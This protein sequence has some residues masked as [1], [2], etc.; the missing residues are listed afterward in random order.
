MIYAYDLNNYTLYND[1]LTMSCFADSYSQLQ[2]FNQQ[3]GQQGLYKNQIGAIGSALAHFS[4]KDEPALIAM[5]TGTGKTAVMVILSYL[6]KANKVLVVTPSQLVREQIA[7]YFRLPKILIDKG[8]IPSSVSLP[9]VY[10]LTTII[11]KAEDWREILDKYDVIVGIPGTLSQIPDLDVTIGKNAF[12]TVF[13]DEA[14]HSRAKSWSFILS[15]FSD[16]RQVLLTATPFRRDK[17][18]IKARLIY[19][20]PLKQ[21]YEDKLFSKINF[22]PVKTQ[23]F[24]TE[25]DKNIA[26]AKKAAEVYLKRKHPDHKIIIRTDR[27]KEAKDLLDIYSEHT[28]L[29]LEVIH[30][31]LNQRTIKQK[32]KQLTTGKINGIICVDMMGE[33]YDFPALKIAAIHIPHK[34]LAITLQFVGRISRTNIAEGDIATVIAGEYEFKIESHQLYKQDTK[35]WS[36]ILPD[37]HS[38]KI[39]KTEDEQDFFDSFEDITEP[40]SLTQLEIDEPLVLDDDDLKPFFH[41]KLYT[42]TPGVTPDLLSETSDDNCPV[43][44]HAQIDFSGTDALKNPVIRH[45]HVSNSYEVAVYVVSE[46]KKPDWYIGSNALRD[47]QNELFVIYFDK[48]NS[49]LFI[50][51]SIK[52]NELY[53]H[54]AIQY[55]SNGAVHEMI[56]LPWLKRA[57]AGWHNPKMYNIGM[58]SRK[59]KGNSETYKQLL[60][61]VAQKGVL[62]TD[63]YSYT[64]GHSFGGAYDAILRRD[65]LL[66][67]STGSKIWSLEENKI[68][69]IVE[70]C[71]RIARKVGDPEMD[72][73][74]SPLSEL[75]CGRVIDRLPDEDIFF[76]DW[77]ASQYH[78]VTKIVFLDQDNEAVET[79]LL[80]SCSIHVLSKDAN[81]ITLVVCKGEAESKI[82]YRIKPKVSFLYAED[83]SCKIA[84]RIGDSYGNTTNFLAILD[85]CPINVFYEDMSKL[86]G[87]V[88]FKFNADNIKSISPEQLIS[89]TW[90]ITVNIHKEYYSETDI[91]NNTARNDQRASIHDYIIELANKEYDAVFYD[92]GSLEIADVIGFKNDKIQFYHCKKQNG[93]VPNCNIDDIYE[94]C[95]QALKSVHWANRKL[96]VKQLYDRA[97]QNDN[98]RKVKKGT[99]P[100]IKDI[101]DSFDNPIIPVE[102]TIVQPGLKTQNL[103]KGQ[104]DALERIKLLLSGA[105][106]FLKEVSSCNLSVMCS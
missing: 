21:A 9:K 6:L 33:G 36:I 86:I 62:P 34:S 26:I 73:L 101:L 74:D 42:I 22:V 7:N 92:H 2:I 68:K 99:L 81:T 38:A 71:Q 31:K 32:I 20:Y 103:T 52:D 78:K 50:C 44:I 104:T 19:N 106:S 83:T 54:I 59:V 46:L 97:E 30:S 35:D 8:V 29:K 80:C 69:N 17:K 16:S 72:N 90:P 13:I 40:E 76:A 65:I 60:G 41:A 53:E 98:H 94:V 63:K 47:V 79:A 102:I 70:W 51:A 87:R 3:N 27:K 18:D 91:A 58:K 24:T 57:M 28:D 84:I 5:P 75:D 85:S 105:A 43:N 49:I 77:D 45:H 48:D 4:T 14:H 25:K 66:G 23:L 55:L 82:I 67:I 10:E 61:S 37:L 95:G 96:M 1:I 100:Q 89:H 11:S 56:P 64:R 15:V 12:D 39:Q 93:D 88:Y